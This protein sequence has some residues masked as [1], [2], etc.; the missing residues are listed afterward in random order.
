MDLYLYGAIIFIFV[1]NLIFYKLFK[2][3]DKS[4]TYKDF[5]VYMIYMYAIMIFLKTT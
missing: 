2:M 5:M 4:L 3:L 1:V